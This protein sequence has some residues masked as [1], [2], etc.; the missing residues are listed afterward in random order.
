MVLWGAE[1][2]TVGVRSK[3]LSKCPNLFQT[4]TAE[5][6]GAHTHS[7]LST[8]TSG[9]THD[10]STSIQHVGFYKVRSKISEPLLTTSALPAGPWPPVSKLKCLIL[11]WWMAF[12]ALSPENLSNK[13]SREDNGKQLILSLCSLCL[14]VGGTCRGSAQVRQCVKG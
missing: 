4:A 13:M 3:Q 7:K 8:P 2:C 12:W 14:W 9:F 1:G 6:D 10:N 11:A 5:P